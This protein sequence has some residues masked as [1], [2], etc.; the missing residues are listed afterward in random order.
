MFY[1]TIPVGENM[2]Q[3]REGRKTE[4]STQKIIEK[5]TARLGKLEAELV[6]SQAT[7]E[8]LLDS[9]AKL[10]NLNHHLKVELDKLTKEDETEK[11]DVDEP[12]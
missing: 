12:D 9:N 1:D 4:I 8:T 5:F 7:N 2:G 3:P 6:I 10:E 11:Q